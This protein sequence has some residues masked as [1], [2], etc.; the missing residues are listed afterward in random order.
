MMDVL[1]TTTTL[2]ADVPPTFTAAP[3]ANPVPVIVIA[4]PPEVE[5]EEG[6]TLVMVGA[7]VVVKLSTGPGVQVPA[8]STHA[9]TKYVV[10]GVIGRRPETEERD[11][12][13]VVL[14]FT[15]PKAGVE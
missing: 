11:P 8:T 10:P 2:V 9:A 5:P 13:N 3:F 12:E 14:A 1:L 6:E 7:D 15:G 4:V